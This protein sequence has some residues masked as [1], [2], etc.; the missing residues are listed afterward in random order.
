MLAWSCFNLNKQHEKPSE[1][2]KN[3]L[4]DVMYLT[5]TYSVVDVVAVFVACSCFERAGKIQ[6][7]S[8]I[9]GMLTALHVSKIW[10]KAVGVVKFH[11]IEIFK[12]KLT[13]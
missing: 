7:Q 1:N 13:V 2:D 6:F 5:A 3:I 8:T 9:L 12:L 10:P 4:I 11:A